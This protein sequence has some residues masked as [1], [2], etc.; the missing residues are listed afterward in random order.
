MQVQL[1]KKYFSAYCLR[2]RCLSISYFNEQCITMKLLLPSAAFRLYIVRLYV[3]RQSF[4]FKV[5][6]KY[7][8][9]ILH[10]INVCWVITLILI[11]ACNSVYPFGEYCMYEIFVVYT[12]NFLPLT[13]LVD[14]LL[15]F[16][17]DSQIL[18]VQIA[19]PVAHWDTASLLMKKSWMNLSDNYIQGYIE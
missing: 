8:C 14:S 5:R 9:W 17:C 7:N 11:S 6:S 16:P 1:I 18:V 10:R 3:I 19:F 15:V 2:C 4:A 12:I 13:C